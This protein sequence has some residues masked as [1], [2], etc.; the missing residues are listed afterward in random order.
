[1]KTFMKI[2]SVLKIS[3]KAA[4]VLDEPSLFLG[5]DPTGI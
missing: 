4:A 5:Q 3:W 2:F 1:M